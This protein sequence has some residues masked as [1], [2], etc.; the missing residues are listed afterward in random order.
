MAAH[1]LASSLITKQRETISTH[2]NAL[3]PVISLSLAQS[4]ELID[5]D[6]G[7]LLLFESHQARLS[8]TLSA[9]L[10]RTGYC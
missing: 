8:S 3:R 4:R 9:W 1:V 7:A 6:A 2:V 5:E 10:R